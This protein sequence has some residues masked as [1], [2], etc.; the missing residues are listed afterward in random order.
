ML[1]SLQDLKSISQLLRAVRGA[2]FSSQTISHSAFG[3]K[4]AKQNTSSTL[5]NNAKMEVI[6][7]NPKN[8]TEVIVTSKYCPKMNMADRT[9]KFI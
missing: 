9:E 5:N 8:A 1:G 2:V 4:L 6:D 7:H 3:P